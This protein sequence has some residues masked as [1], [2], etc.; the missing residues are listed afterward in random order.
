MMREDSDFVE[1]DG[2]EVAPSSDGLHS[3]LSVSDKSHHER[4]ALLKIDLV[5]IPLMGMYCEYRARYIGALL[6]LRLDT[7]RP[8]VFLG[9]LSPCALKPTTLTTCR[10]ARESR[11]FEA[12]FPR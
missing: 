11:M 10:I 8:A 3:S 12:I 7:S 9:T 2:E 6:I 4:K 5:V 1:K